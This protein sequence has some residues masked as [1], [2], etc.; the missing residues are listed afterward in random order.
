M[1]TSTIDLGANCN[2]STL[3]ARI[4]SLIGKSF[5]TNDFYKQDASGGVFVSGVA[6]GYVISAYNHPSK[7]HSATASG[8]FLGCGSEKSVASAGKWAV[9]WVCM[10]VAN[11]RSYYGFS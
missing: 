7:Y 5:S 11:R 4:S 8:G 3:V 1:P 10:G 2:Y 9:A 6:N